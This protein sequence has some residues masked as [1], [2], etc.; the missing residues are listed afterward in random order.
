MWLRR[1]GTVLLVAGSLAVVD[2]VLTIAWRE[3]ATAYLAWR[4]QVRLR[5]DFD[6]RLARHPGV[7]ASLGDAPPDLRALARA[8]RREIGPHTP[9][10]RL[11]IPEIGLAVIVA[12][13]THDDAEQIVR[14]SLKE[15]PAHLPL[16][17]LPGEGRTVAVAGH[18]TTYGAPFRHLDDLDPGDAI[19]LQTTYGRF[20]YR[21]SSVRVVRPEDIAVLA[22]VP[23]RERLVLSACHPVY[24]AARRI[25]VSADLERT[26]VTA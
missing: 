8:E 11:R 4:D 19:T 20:A 14:D 12:E 10:A 6:A 17:G 13:G 22:D 9:I 3:P 7:L 16:S 25:V 21:V 5:H 2:G 24:S 18:R 26:Q 15:G 1:L 23:G